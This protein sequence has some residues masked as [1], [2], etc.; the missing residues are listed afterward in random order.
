MKIK[1]TGKV[2]GTRN[3]ADWPEVGEVIDLPDHEALDLIAAGMATDDLKNAKGE[4]RAAEPY[5]SVG[6]AS[7]DYPDGTNRTG[8]PLVDE[9]GE[10]AD[11]GIT[12]NGDH[13]SDEGE[14]PEAPTVPD[15]ARVEP[16][17]TV[18]KVVETKP[19][20]KG[21]GKK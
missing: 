14:Q 16:T 4:A 15:D 17:T 21:K 13:L 1:M 5:E 3:G 8:A 20:G 19:S 18:D 10:V 12:V 11:E 7:G 2:S 9:L 6:V